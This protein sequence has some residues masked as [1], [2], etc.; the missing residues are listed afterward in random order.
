MMWLQ[1]CKVTCPSEM[2]NT[3]MSATIYGF[4]V[5]TNLVFLKW[6]LQLLHTRQQTD[7]RADLKCTHKRFNT[8]HQVWRNF[9][10]KVH[11]DIF[12][13]PQKNVAVYWPTFA[14]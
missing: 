4:I 6:F 9:E 8:F 5:L 7:V 2:N 13:T 11:F 14:Y 10:A 3:L 12:K 1:T